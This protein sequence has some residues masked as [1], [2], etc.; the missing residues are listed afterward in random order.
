L[1]AIGLAWG[2]GF[3]HSLLGGGPDEAA[4]NVAACAFVFGAIT[5]MSLHGLR[6]LAWTS[7]PV[8]LTFEAILGFIAIPLFRFAM[9]YA[10]LD[11]EYVRAMSLTL[12]G[13]VAFWI[14][15]LVFKCSNPG[16]RYVAKLPYT[17]MRLCIIAASMMTIGIIGNLILWRTGLFGYAQDPVLR[18][19]HSGVLPWLTLSSDMLGYALLVAA[20]EVFGKRSS[21]KFIQSV[22]WLSLSCAIAFGVISGMKSAPISPLVGIML[23]YVI[24]RRQMP[25]SIV[26][27]PIVL[28]TI[29]YPFATA[30]RSNLN[31]G[32]RA[33]FNTVQ[34]LEDT[35]SQSFNDAFHSFGSNSRESRRQSLQ[36]TTDRLSYLTY[37]RDVST[38][39]FPEMLN[40]D[41]K[42]WLAPFYPF[43]PRLFWP[44]KPILNKGQRLSILLGRGGQTSSALTPIG[45][46]YALY[47]R[48]GIVAGMFLWGV[49]LQAYVNWSSGKIATERLVFIYALMLPQLVNFEAD[50]TILVAQSVQR[51][52]VTVIVSFLVYGTPST[53]KGFHSRWRVAQA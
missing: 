47:G 43:V 13:F 42:V 30:F 28:I 15:S 49:C 26:F 29:I 34:G 46:L 35:V 25:Q 6:N 4:F 27:L 39:P 11:A 38:L 17:P 20:I 52:L 50:V 12:I 10:A 16:I 5:Y 18:A 19:S 53:A 23:V 48:Y 31:S 22:L 36:E 37:V 51:L 32:Y 44:D 7:V 21:Q 33:Q 45:D 40:G 2:L 9:G 1:L 8:L 41:E 24:T 14:G 3:T